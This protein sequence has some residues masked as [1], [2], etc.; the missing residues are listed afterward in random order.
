ML[1]PKED[2]FTHAGLEKEDAK[3][4]PV[5][6]VKQSPVRFEC[7]F[8]R[9]IQLP[10]NP[11]MGT[12]DIIFGKVLAVHISD[13]VLTDGKID[14]AKTEPIARLGYYDYAVIRETFEMKI[15]GTNKALLDGLEGSSRANRELEGEGKEGKEERGQVGRSLSAGAEEGIGKGEKESGK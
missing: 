13:S 2:E 15:P 8:D 11:P 6:L 12:V 10:G 3:T 7:Q 4:I 14:I 9:C 5:P 1:D